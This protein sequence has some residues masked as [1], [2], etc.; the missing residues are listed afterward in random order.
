MDQAGAALSPSSNDCKDRIPLSLEE[1]KVCEAL[2]SSVSPPYTSS[3][4]TSFKAST[5]ILDTLAP[6]N[7]DGKTSPI[8]FFFF[9]PFFSVEK[10]YPHPSNFNLDEWDE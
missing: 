10:L 1:K 5:G 6:E 2:A 8:Y 7:V 3:L 4:H 9:F